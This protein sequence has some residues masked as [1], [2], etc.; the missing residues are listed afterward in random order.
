MPASRPSGASATSWFPPINSPRGPPV[1]VT[2]AR[3]AH[4]PGPPGP[5]IPSP[6]DAVA[7]GDQ[8]TNRLPAVTA[9]RTGSGSWLDGIRP[10][11]SLRARLI[12]AFAA[13]IF[14]TLF[15]VGIGFV[16]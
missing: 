15:L 8:P 3:P 12:L 13:I 5:A 11:H 9:D 4:P 10:A 6:P 7:P 2:R 16:F 14:L 1:A